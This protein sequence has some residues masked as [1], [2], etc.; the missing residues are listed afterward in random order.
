MKSGENVRPI[1]DSIGFCWS[2]T[3]MNNFIDFLSKQIPMVEDESQNLFA[4]ISVHD[5]Y[6]YAGNV[7]YP[8][9]KNIKAK[10]V[11]IFGVTHGSVTK[12][13]GPLSDIIILD[14]YQ[15]WR[16][17]YK[18]VEISPLRE[19][20]KSKL[21]KNYFIVSDKAQSIE[22]SI[23]ALIPFLQYYNRDIKITPIMVTRM[24]LER[25]DDLST[26]LSKIIIDYT[27]S[28]KLELGKD[29]FF[30]ISNDANHYGE[31][32]NNAVYGLDSTAHFL[33]TENDKKIINND[34]VG[35][36]TENKILE[37]AKD[38]LPDSA[39]RNVPLWCG[40][41][42]IIF[43]LMT[44]SKIV[45]D[46]VDSHFYGKL[47]KYSDTFTEKVLPVKNTSMGLTAVFSY[48]HWCGWFTSGFYLT[49]KTN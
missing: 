8:L 33:A 48:R 11:V 1:R 34:L 5:D 10:E 26:R 4:A 42:P 47:F 38:I 19:I 28:N 32:F 36:I 43:G 18:D 40:R 35:L 45:D 15:K 13:M 44:I 21:S 30:L 3:E 20:I 17:P 41:Y 22:H 2:A 23:E 27:K 46:L 49:K 7:Y 12:E 29:I 14:E 9:Y 31:D 39:N 6:L 25:M 24:P 16:G 37:T